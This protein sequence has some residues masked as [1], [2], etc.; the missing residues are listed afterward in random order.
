MPLNYF[1]RRLVS[2][3]IFSDSDCSMMKSYIY[4][5]FLFLCASRTCRARVLMPNE[6]TSTSTTT[7][8]LPG[9]NPTEFIVTEQNVA[10]T[11]AESAKNQTEKR[12]DTVNLDN[13]IRVYEGDKLEELSDDEMPKEVEIE[14]VKERK[15]CNHRHCKENKCTFTVDGTEF[16]FKN[17]LGAYLKIDFVELFHKCLSFRTLFPIFRSPSGKVVA[18]IAGQTDISPGTKPHQKFTFQINLND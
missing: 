2:A 18:S 7:E 16:S 12:N 13:T 14:N 6:T 9:E 5:T 8:T 15:C 11:E 4:L 17:T 1:S 3:K 10:T